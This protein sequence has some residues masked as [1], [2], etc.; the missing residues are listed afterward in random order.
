MNSTH[1]EMTFTL[2]GLNSILPKLSGRGSAGTMM[3]L[4]F[5]AS[6]LLLL[7]SGEKAAP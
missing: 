4:P 7:P 6:S 1:F 3:S 5:P 2:G